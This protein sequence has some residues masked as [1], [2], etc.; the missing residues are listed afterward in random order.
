MY[1]LEKWEAPKQR[2]R[3]VQAKRWESSGIM[4]P[5]LQKV[6]TVS[7]G[8]FPPLQSLLLGSLEIGALTP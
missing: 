8:V 4:A 7:G 3:M 2:G 1:R 6:T 5:E